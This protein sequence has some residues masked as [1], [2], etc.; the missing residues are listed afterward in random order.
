MVFYLS[1]N[2]LI[3]L[4]SSEHL[5]LLQTDNLQYYAEDDSI[6]DILKTRYAASGHFFQSQSK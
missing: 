6:C 1:L 5:L 4:S 2:K 3:L